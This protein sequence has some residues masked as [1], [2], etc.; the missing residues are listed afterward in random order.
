VV[1]AQKRLYQGVPVAQRASRRVFV[2]VLSPHGAT[3][4]GRHKADAK[5]LAA[6]VTAS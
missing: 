4:L 6:R 5:P 3:R 1:E 2:P